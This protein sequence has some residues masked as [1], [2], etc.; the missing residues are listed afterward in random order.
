MS[1]HQNPEL[2]AIILC[3]SCDLVVAK[4]ALPS[5]V[6]ALCPRCHTVLF[7]APFCTIN[8]LLA[9]CLTALIF[10][11]PAVTMSVLEL[12]FLGSVRTATV[13]DGAYIVFEQGYWIVGLAVFIV[14][15][16]A[17]GLLIS[18]IFLQA[19]IVKS[20][21][22]TPFWLK[23]YKALL[24]SQNLLKQF[25]M[26]EIYII[27]LLVTTFNLADFADMHFSMGTFCYSMLFITM[28]FLQ[29]EYNLEYMWAQVND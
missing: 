18:S 6:R 16:V 19:I 13:F 17:P 3:H 24:K 12:H 29:R 8:G 10:F 5:N 27:S 26:P 11:I 21:P 14:A 25:S 23:T 15:I 4:R 20:S 9:L 7:D 1:R 22:I 28:I 2:N